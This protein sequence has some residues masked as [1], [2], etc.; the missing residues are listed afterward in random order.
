[1]IGVWV[2]EH[3]SV[4]VASTAG[5][6]HGGH[7][8]KT[9]IHWA[10]RGA[11]PVN[12]HRPAVGKVDQNTVS[13]ADVQHRDSELASWL[14]DFER[15]NFGQHKER[16]AHSRHKPSLAGSLQHREARDCQHREVPLAG[17]RH[18]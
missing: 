15:R 6:K 16:S 12:E 10:S 17:T 1:V 18:G 3:E 11:S 14:A 13:L 9:G 7:Y 2:G 8:A 4:N 5:A